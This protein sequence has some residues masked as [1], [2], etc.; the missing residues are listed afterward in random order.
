MN[1]A[2]IEFSVQFWSWWSNPLIGMHDDQRYRLAWPIVNPRDISYLS[3]LELR[4]VLELDDIPD[5]LLSYHPEMRALAHLSNEEFKTRFQP[6]SYWLLDASVLNARPQDWEQV[7]GIS[8]PDEIRDIISQRAALPG[9]LLN[10]HGNVARTLNLN[11]KAPLFLTERASVCFL[12]Y[13]RS[14]Y[15]RFYRRWKLTQSDAVV[16]ASQ[17]LDPIPQELWD[18]FQAWAQPIFKGL[19]EISAEQAVMPEFELEFQ[20]DSDDLDLDEFVSEA[21]QQEQVND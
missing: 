19:E 12:I 17:L 6:F 1:L 2:E 21:P 5:E 7:Y 10:W 9:A 16:Q 15:P 13:L 18:T 3:L 20:E 8:S 11:L 4:R 14:F